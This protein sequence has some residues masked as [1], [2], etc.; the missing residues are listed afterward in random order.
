MTTFKKYSDWLFERSNKVPLNERIISNHL[1]EEGFLDDLDDTTVLWTQLGLSAIGLIPGLGVPADVANILISFDR[2]DW[3]GVALGLLG[4]LPVLGDAIGNVGNMLRFSIGI[5]DSGSITIAR[6]IILHM[7]QFV[8]RTPNILSYINRIDSFI[9]STS[10]EIIN[11][12]RSARSGTAIAGMSEALRPLLAVVND[13]RVVSLLRGPTGDNILTGLGVAFQNIR[14][15]LTSLA[16][17]FNTV[18][19]A[20]ENAETIERVYRVLVE[21]EVMPASPAGTDTP[22]G[23]LSENFIYTDIRF[24]RLARIL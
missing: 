3:L 2:Q 7:I 21:P 20:A 13:S 9:A 5:A 22:T 24:K 14:R 17:I 11:L 6:P 4:M 10:T 23:T 8:E 1:L 12:F 19:R 16:S 18:G 15:I